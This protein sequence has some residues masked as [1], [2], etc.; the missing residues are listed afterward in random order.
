[1]CRDEGVQRRGVGARQHGGGGVGAGK[2]VVDVIVEAILGVGLGIAAALPGKGQ[3]LL[4]GLVMEDRAAQQLVLRVPNLRAVAGDVT[5]HAADFLHKRPDAVPGP[6][7]GGDDTNA[8]GC[9]P[10]KGGKGQGRQRA[11]VPQ[12]AAV[13]CRKVGNGFF[14][15]MGEQPPWI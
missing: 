7:A 4:G 15:P 11:V 2:G 3:D 10:P 8:P 9:G 1:M 14:M 6:P 12:A 5:G 13:S